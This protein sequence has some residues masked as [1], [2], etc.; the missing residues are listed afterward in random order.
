M[1]GSDD[2]E[3]VITSSTTKAKESR[4]AALDGERVAW[5]DLASP[6]HPFFFE[7]LLS[8]LPEL[9]VE[10]TFREKTETVALG[11][12]AGFD[13]RVIGRDAGTP[14]LRKAGIVVRTAQLALGTPACDVSLSARNAMCVLASRCRGVPSIH[15]T[16][17]D[18]TAYA[19]GLVAERL[20]NRIEASATH[21]VVPSAFRTEELTRWGITTDR[22]HTYDGYKEDLSVAGFEP[23]PRFPE[24]LPVSEYLLIRPE[25]LTAAYVDER[26]GTLVLDLL[27]GA[28]ARGYDVV[29]LP[30]GRGDERLARGYPDDRVYVPDAPLDGRE[31]AWNARCVLTGSGTMAREAACMDKPAV[32]FFPGPL[33][34]VDRQLREEGRLY[35]SREPDAI[36]EYMDS[37]DDRDARPDRERSVAVRDEVARLTAALI[38]EL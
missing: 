24:R 6:S 34:S 29:Y 14:R 4:P 30:R 19:D 17:N 11:R 21:S 32:S 31:L 38:E 12:T 26:E 9:S 28:L 27:D 7:G 35:H 22:I 5:V 37:L 18:I 10:P 15:F 23:D 3:S 16:D 2:V 1:P 33:L 20:Y 25:A 36:L 13:G 8:G